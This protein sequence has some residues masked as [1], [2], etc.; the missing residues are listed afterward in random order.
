MRYI[1]E[2]HL[3]CQMD[4][5]ANEDRVWAGRVRLRDGTRAV[6]ACVADGVGGAQHGA[7]VAEIAVQML[8]NAL[9]EACAD[10]LETEV[11]ANEWARALAESLQSAVAA[12]YAGGF[13]TL[14]AVVQCGRRRL[15]LNVGD[16]GAYW[17]SRDSARRLTDEHTVASWML[18]GGQAEEE[19]PA[20]M[21]KAL[22]RAL[23]KQAYGGELF[24]V[25][26]EACNEKRG[27]VVVA[28]DGVLDYI[29]GTELRAAGAAATSAAEMA[30]RIMR[31]T[32][33]L[34]RRSG[35]NLDNASLAVLALRPRAATTIKWVAALAVLALIPVFWLLP[36]GDVKTPDE[37]PHFEPVT[38][39]TNETSGVI[40]ARIQLLEEVAKLS[41]FKIESVKIEDYNRLKIPLSE[42]WIRRDSRRLV[43]IMGPKG[44]NNESAS[45]VLM[46]GNKA[47]TYKG[48]VG[49]REW[50]LVPSRNGGDDD[51]EEASITNWTGDRVT[52]NE[53]ISSLFLTNSTLRRKGK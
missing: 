24:D 32:L 14:C 21:F 43:H 29:G 22:H 13:S 49:T 33:R 40:W 39:A 12:Q 44:H 28:S 25:A 4:R 20:R 7:E 34:G 51:G 11:A 53:T 23:G 3:S 27:W 9:Q 1:G 36:G 30:R 48:K 16:S 50:E 17:V 41:S 52:N 8:R 15:V 18:Q 42:F 47:L 35:R 38:S 19:I 5:D 46:V 37:T 2:F 10:I 26:I 31:E 45:V 6:L